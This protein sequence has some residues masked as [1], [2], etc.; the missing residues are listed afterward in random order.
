MNEWLHEVYDNNLLTLENIPGA[1][2]PNKT[3]YNLKVSIILKSAT[4]DPVLR[5]KNKN[6]SCLP[7]KY[8]SLLTVKD[9]K[10]NANMFLQQGVLRYIPCSMLLT[11]LKATFHSI[12]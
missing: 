1:V 7:E 12:V 5:L 9:T 10:E 3:R 8:F 11:K 4:Y 6:I 2:F